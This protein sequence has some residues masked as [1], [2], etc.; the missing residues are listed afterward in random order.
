MA[1]RVKSPKPAALPRSL[2][3]LVRLMPPLAIRDD[4]GHENTLEMIDRLMRIDR[5]TRDQGDYMETLV[6]LVEAYE[7]RHHAIDT[8]DLTGRQMLQF[9]LDQAGHSASDLARMLDMHPTMGSK[10]LKGERRLT[11]DH[12]KVLA[13]HFKLEPAVFM[14]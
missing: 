7:A 8:S 5:L 11:W 13:A 14:D 1:I 2:A 4:V 3:E 6:E 12:A 10:L 9:V